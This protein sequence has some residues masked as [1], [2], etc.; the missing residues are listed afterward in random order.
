MRLPS[1]VLAVVVALASA[2]GPAGPRDPNA[3]PD[4]AAPPADAI[5]TASGL[6]YKVL[7]QGSGS[8]HPTAASTVLAN[9]TGWTTSGE[10][11]DSSFDH[12]APISF[13]LNGVI[14]GWTEGL[15]LM[16]IGEK[17]RFWIPGSLAYD[18]VP[19]RPQGMLVFDV[20][21]LDIK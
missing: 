19:D 11:F 4:V 3:P 5:R 7:T 12:G 9:Y 14:R 17:C 2:C 16:V 15:Q 21:L 6:A 18:G 20:E 1:L 8:I 10:K 13:P